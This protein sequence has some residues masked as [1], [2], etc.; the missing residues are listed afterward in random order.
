[1]SRASD[2]RDAV[3]TELTTRL[4]TYTVE[5]FVVPHYTREELTSG[6]KIA[7]RIAEREVEIDQGPDVRN[8]A[9]EVGVVGVTPA[10]SGAVSS[11]HRSQEVAACDVFDGLMET[12]ISYWSPNGPLSRCGM[13]EHRFLSIEQTV[14]FDPQ[15]LFNDGIW[16]SLIRL[17]YQDA[18]D[19]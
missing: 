18:E 11:A 14:N 6:A 12:I 3:I 13:A 5:A 17:N 8:I 4:S 7:V 10:L 2:L 19:Q 15:K 1:M 16:L 9:I